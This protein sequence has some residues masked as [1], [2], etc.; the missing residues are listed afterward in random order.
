MLKDY[1]IEQDLEE[2]EAKLPTKKITVNANVSNNTTPI[3][4]ATRGKLKDSEQINKIVKNF[5][6][7]M[8]ISKSSASPSKEESA[9]PE[10]IFVK[11]KKTDVE[12][13]TNTEYEI[14]DIIQVK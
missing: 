2:I 13:D 3:K 14:E 4:R 6:R 5:K 8:I 1:K 7:K 11:P 10:K 9:S 12:K